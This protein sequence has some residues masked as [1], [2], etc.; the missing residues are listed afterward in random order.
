MEKTAIELFAGVGGFRVGLNNITSIDLTG[1]AVENGD[2]HFLWANQWEPGKKSQHAYDCY[3]KRFGEGSCLCKDISTVDV[4]DI[5]DHTLLTA[6]F[7][8]QDYS[9][10]HPK[11]SEKGIEGKKG[12][13]WWD[14]NRIV[15]AKKPAFILLENVDRLLKA[16]SAQRG[17]AFGIILR[18]LSD[19]G[20][21]IQWRVI[22]AADYGH[23][24]KRRRTFIFAFRNDTNY[25]DKFVKAASKG[26]ESAILTATIFSNGFPCEKKTDVVQGSIYGKKYETL[27]EVSKL[28]AFS[29]ENSGFCIDGGFSTMSVSSTYVGPH[30]TLGECLVKPSEV[31]EFC[32]KANFEKFKYLKSAKK[33]KRVAKNGH[34]YVFSE[35]AIPFPDKLD[36]P[37]RTMLTSEGSTNRTSHYILDPNTNKYRILAPVE[38]ER[39]DEF[40]SYWTETGMPE[41]FRYFIA[42]NAL[43]CGII[44]T[45]G[46]QLEQIIK[47]EI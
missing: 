30:K 34:E 17:Q 19:A 26:A 10:A 12:V 14:I 28:F 6:G 29:F 9:V 16:P 32:Y 24:Q 46:E 40:P 21:G 41:K 42:G 33:I 43:V 47:T 15:L 20:Y 44:E 25:Y 31:P 13:L 23:P 11:N 38:C 8:C 1:R 45:I 36:T 4:A 3:I 35:G 22:N 39:L 7:P 27:V 37:S 18:C 5:P 2:W